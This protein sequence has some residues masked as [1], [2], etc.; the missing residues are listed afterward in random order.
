LLRE[1]FSH[2]LRFFSKFL[3]C[4]MREVVEGCDMTDEEWL[5]CKDLFLMLRFLQ[6]KLSDRKLRLFA[7]ACCR[8]HWD[9]FVEPHARRAVEVAEQF[10]DGMATE[11]EREAA[12]AVSEEAFQA[13]SALST[14]WGASGAAAGSIAIDRPV[15]E[16]DTGPFGWTSPKGAIVLQTLRNLLVALGSSRTPRY[17]SRRE[18]RAN[19]STRRLK[20]SCK[21]LLR[22][23]AECATLLREICGYPFRPV[24]VNPAWLSWHDGLLVSMAQQMYDARDFADMPILGDA[25]EEAGCDNADILNHCRQPGEHVRG[26]WV[27]DLILGK[28]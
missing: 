28:S 18:L 12:H 5:S 15:T 23:F 11:K 3:S 9:L 21:Q 4:Q 14:N 6:W 2:F 22:D 27:V 7:V 24:T 16:D 26:C 20:Q 17:T 1:Q 10:A 8:R 25:L 13:T 19:V